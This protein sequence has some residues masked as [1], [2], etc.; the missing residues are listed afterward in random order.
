MVE[1][2]TQKQLLKRNRT[3]RNIW[4]NRAGQR[5]GAALVEF[6][7]VAPLMMLFTMGLIDLGRMTMVRQLIINASNSP[8]IPM[9]LFQRFSRYCPIPELPA[10]LR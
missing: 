7:L 4:S 9:P 1:K 2:T 5:N 6:A 10:P 3:Q 8:P